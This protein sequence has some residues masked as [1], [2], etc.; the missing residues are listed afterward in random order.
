MRFMK[1]QEGPQVTFMRPD[2]QISTGTLQT[3]STVSTQIVLAFETGP[4]KGVTLRGGYIPWEPSDET[5]QQAFYFGAPNAQ[6]APATAQDAMAGNG[7]TVYTMSRCSAKAPSCNFSSVFPNVL[8]SD[9]PE[10]YIKNSFTDI[11]DQNIQV[12][13]PCQTFDT[14]SNCIA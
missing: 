14:C 2:G 13:D 3:D 11:E 4:L 6:E 10:T 8:S 12:T 5:E 9:M 1:R 7:A